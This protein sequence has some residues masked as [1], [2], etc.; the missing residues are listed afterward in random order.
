MNGARLHRQFDKA[1][2]EQFRRIASPHNSAPEGRQLLFGMGADLF[3]I[4]LAAGQ[5]KQFLA[6]DLHDILGAVEILRGR[7]RLLRPV[8]A[9]VGKRHEMA[10]EVA[11]IDGRNVF[12]LERPERL[13]IVPI[14]KMA[15][16]LLHLLDGRE[17]RLDPGERVD[18]TEP[19]EFPGAGGRQQIKTD[20]GGRRPVRDDRFR[21]FLEVVGRQHVVARPDEGFEKRPGPARHDTQRQPVFGR[22]RQFIGG[23]LQV[24]EPRRDRRRG[25]PQHREG[26]G[27][28]SRTVSPHG[29]D[30]ESQQS[31]HDARRHELIG[32]RQSGPH[33]GLNLRGG[34]PLQEI[35]AARVEPVKRAHDRIGQQ[36]RL[37][38]HQ[39][40]IGGSQRRGLSHVAG[41]HA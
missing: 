3:E 9:E 22:R 18:K 33:A 23:N 31:R 19:A 2:H 40:E 10:A 21:I 28:K 26:H 6:Q 16:A 14:V 4:A 32:S 7:G 34:H 8:T 5:C 15:L 17:R 30:G 38:A 35:P 24:T 27:G 39:H 37:V 41:K 11:A 13:G 36:S 20:V 25:K 12:G 1:H 29:G